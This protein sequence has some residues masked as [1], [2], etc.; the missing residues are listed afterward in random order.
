[1]MKI[2][3]SDNDVVLNIVSCD[4][5]MLLYEHDLYRWI[6]IMLLWDDSS[7]GEL[8]SLGQC[9]FCLLSG[10]D[11]KHYV[12]VALTC[13]DM[14]SLCRCCWWKRQ[15]AIRA[16][17]N[18]DLSQIRAWWI[19]GSS[20][21][22]LIHEWTNWWWYGTIYIWV[23][24]KLWVSLHNLNDEYVIALCMLMDWVWEW[25]CVIVVECVDVWILPC[26]LYR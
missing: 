6:M 26:S 19:Q 2:C 7:G 22:N 24:L 12:V 14:H 13:C 25:C 21:V 15:V 16:G 1:M 8:L 10:G 3:E 11:F 5:D 4:I 17:W 9:M 23:W 20:R 18:A